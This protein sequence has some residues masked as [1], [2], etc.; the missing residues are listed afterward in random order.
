M[1]LEAGKYL[2][3]SLI[4]FTTF[5]TTGEEL[6]ESANEFDKSPELLR[7]ILRKERKIT[8]KNKLLVQ[9]LLSKGVAKKQLLM[10]LLN[11]SYREAKK[12]IE[13]YNNQQNTWGDL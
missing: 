1:A 5:F 6:K 11:S 10:P 8:E 9:S 2:S 4:T 12:I 3:D 13:S 7:A